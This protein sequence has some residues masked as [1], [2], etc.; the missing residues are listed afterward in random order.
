[1]PH[2]TCFAVGQGRLQWLPYS[3]TLFL[4]VSTVKYSHTHTHM[5]TQTNF[6]C[7]HA[8]ITM[9][10]GR[11]QHPTLSTPVLRPWR[12]TRR[13]TLARSTATKASRRCIS[14]SIISKVER[15]T[16]WAT[17]QP[18]KQTSQAAKQPSKPS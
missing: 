13:T 4:Q 7:A 15:G 5:Q 3:R 14:S 18:S 11:I 8:K 2:V 6:C 1:M 9:L 16:H 17:T 10:R 12:E